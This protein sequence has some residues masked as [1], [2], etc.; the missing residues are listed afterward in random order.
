M[1]N[2]EEWDRNGS[3]IERA[4]PR[5]ANLMVGRSR[6]E[7]RQAVAGQSSIQGACLTAARFTAR[8]CVGRPGIP[9]CR[10]T[11]R[12]RLMILKAGEGERRSFVAS[13]MEWLSS[14]VHGNRCCGL[15]NNTSVVPKGRRATFRTV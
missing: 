2:L 5:A 8:R 14:H 9:A 4:I 6:Y 7:R 3:R 13:L 10:I 15:R 1:F 11:H 12:R